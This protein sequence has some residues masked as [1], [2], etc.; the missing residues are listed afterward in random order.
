[1]LRKIFMMFVLPKLIA[2]FSRRG[3]R[4]RHGRTY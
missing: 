4:P 3:A 1:M 2:H